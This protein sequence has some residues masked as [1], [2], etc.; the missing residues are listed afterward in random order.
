MTPT[1]EKKNVPRRHIDTHTWYFINKNEVSVL[2][3][4]SNGHDHY[5]V[6]Y[7]VCDQPNKHLSTVFQEIGI[8]FKC[9]VLLPL[10]SIM[11]HGAQT[12]TAF[13]HMYIY[14][15]S[16]LKSKKT[17]EHQR[18]VTLLPRR[19]KT[20]SKR[21]TNCYRTISV[22]IYILSTIFIDF[23]WVLWAVG[24]HTHTLN[25][26][27]IHWIPYFDSILILRLKIDVIIIL[28]QYSRYSFRGLNRILFWWM[29]EGFTHS[30][31]LLFFFSFS[32]FV[33]SWYFII[34]LFFF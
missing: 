23:E 7:C 6:M 24:E 4:E 28:D 21:K 2:H 5:L 31:C 14:I 34:F 30:M 33:S 22:Q 8:A 26:I 29:I 17:N 20:K 3:L 11:F 9:H 27:E 13:K 12:I 19:M 1:N 10:Q 18:T 25:F 16:D 15:Y 32:S